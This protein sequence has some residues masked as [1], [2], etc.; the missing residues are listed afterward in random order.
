M[1]EK[2]PFTIS[3]SR[4]PVEYIDRTSQT[5]QI[6]DTFTEEP[7]TDQIFIITGVRGAGKTVLM[8]SI[9]NALEQK[10]DWLTWRAIVTRD[11]VHDL[12]A[13]LFASKFMSRI[14]VSAAFGIPG[15]GSVS[16]GG[17]E[18]EI[19]DVSKIRTALK[20]MGKA[21]KKLLVTVDEISNTKQ[22][23]DFSGVFQSLIGENLP[24]YLLGTAIPENMDELKNVKFLTFLYRAPKIELTPLDMVSIAFRYKDIFDLS[25]EESVKM[26][27]LTR[28]YSYA[29]Q[30]LG[31]VY[32]NSRPVQS[33]DS[34]MPEYDRLLA[35]NS[36]SKI[37]VELSE[38]QREVCRA[39]AKCKTGRVSDVRQILRMDSNNFNGYRNRLMHQ[40]IIV[41]ND[42][43]MISFSLPRFSEFINNYAELYEM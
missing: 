19:S 5:E 38:K 34:V 20:M 22:L 30:A 42:W 7:V 17:K 4:K 6:M 31:Y 18:R 8:S 11:I 27:K 13:D 41:K 2:N 9:A 15:V 37:W 28:G 29:F 39:I 26:A 32:W 3:F 33:L 1:A 43:G 14:D 24:I 16:V 21:G 25:E 10:E 23:Q 35:S 12:A 36:Y 40:G